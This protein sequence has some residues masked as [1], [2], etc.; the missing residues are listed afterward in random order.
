MA[1]GAGTLL[2]SG[3]VDAVMRVLVDAEVPIWR[4]WEVRYPSVR[5]RE[6]FCPPLY[7]ITCCLDT[8]N[9]N[10]MSVDLR[11]AHNLNCL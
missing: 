1:C 8:G 9:K 3:V 5:R 2:F 10:P 6:T 4:R 11:R 7:I